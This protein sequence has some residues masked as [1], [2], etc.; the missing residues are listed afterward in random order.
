MAVAPSPSSPVSLGRRERRAHSGESSPRCRV[1]PI[2]RQPP[3]ALSRAVGYAEWRKR[4]VVVPKVLDDVDANGARRLLENPPPDGWVTGEQAFSVL[5][6]YGIPVATT[7]GVVSAS[8]AASA[9]S[10]IGFPVALKATGPG[11]VHKSDVGGV[12]LALGTPEAV[13]AAYSEMAG[14]IGDAMDGAVV[15][16][17]AQGGSETIVGF[18]QDP[19]F[20]PLVLFGLGGTAVELLGDYATCRVPLTEIEAHEMLLSLRG[21]PLLTGYRGSAPVNLEA[22]VDLVLR[23]GQLAEDLPEL[24]EADLNPVM[25]TPEGALVVDARLRVSSDPLVQDD[26]RHLA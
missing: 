6:A 9:A 23:C 24:A 5:Q 21:A 26:T 18:V 2:P 25:A 13:M 16:A 11:I 14:A 17:M 22:L 8:Q 10:S 20:G 1:S 3:R 19:A 15:Q 4:P 12:R 7:V